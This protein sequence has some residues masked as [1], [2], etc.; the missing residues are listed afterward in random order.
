[1]TV[2]VKCNGRINEVTS[3]SERRDA[4]ACKAAPATA[5]PLFRCD[6]GG[7]GQYYWWNE[8]A[9]SSAGRAKS[10]CEGLFRRCVREGVKYDGEDMGMFEEVEL[11]PPE[12]E[13]KKRGVRGGGKDGPP[14]VSEWLTDPALK[15]DLGAFT[16]VYGPDELP[17]TNLTCSF[18]GTL[19]YIFLQSDDPRI[20]VLG[21]LDLPKKAEECG[22]VLPSALWPSDH[23]PLATALKFEKQEGDHDFDHDHGENCDCGFKKIP[24]LFE[25]AQMRKEFEKK[26]KEEKEAKTG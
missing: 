24:G 14:P 19:D 9:A 11:E 26:R 15:N 2:C 4:Y 25:M 1:M 16:S 21:V 8:K 12:K 3:E 22:G 5:K 17:F 7:C 18:R 23:L 6:G 20:S 13:E 10:M